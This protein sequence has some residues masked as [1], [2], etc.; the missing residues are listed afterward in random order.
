MVPLAL[1]PPA[2]PLTLQVTAV[3][4]AFLTVAVNCWVAPGFNCTCT[5]ATATVIGAAMVTWAEPDLVASAWLVAVTVS[6]AGEGTAAGA[7]KLPLES[8]VPSVELP[9]ATP[10]TLQMTAVLLSPVTLAAKFW[11]APRSTVAVAGL[12]VT[13]TVCVRVTVA[14]A[15][16]AGSWTLA[17]PMVT[18]LKPWKEA[19]AV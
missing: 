18:W 13:A 10:L 4:L 14:E 2:V 6:C 15:W 5:G 11:V 19:G 1:L 8:I 17:T 9:P 3:L 12:T 7:V 16:T